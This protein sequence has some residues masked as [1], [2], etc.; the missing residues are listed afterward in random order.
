MRIFQSS[1]L[2][3]RYIRLFLIVALCWWA[4]NHL[5]LGALIR[6]I[7]SVGANFISQAIDTIQ[8]R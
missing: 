7:E 3:Y 2:L 8:R 4:Y 6:D 5:D 1:L